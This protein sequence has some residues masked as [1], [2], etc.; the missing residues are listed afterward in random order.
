[1]FERDGDDD[2]VVDRAE[3]GLVAMGFGFGGFGLAAW[4]PS[5][6][7]CWPSLPRLADLEDERCRRRRHVAAYGWLRLRLRMR[8]GV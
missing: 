3:L 7:A 2:V 1:M 8:G 4:W 6:A 5:L